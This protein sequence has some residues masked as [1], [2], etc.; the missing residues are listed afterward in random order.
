MWQM[1]DKMKLSYYHSFQ[2]SCTCPFAI[3]AGQ[4]LAFEAATEL[5]YRNTNL[6][7]MRWTYPVTN[8]FLLE[9]SASY[10]YNHSQVE[11]GPDTLP[12][13][14]NITELSTG[15]Q[16]GSTANTTFSGVALYSLTPNYSNAFFM[17]YGGT[18]VTGSHAFKVG[19]TRLSGVQASSGYVQNNGIAYTFNNQKPTGLTLYATPGWSESKVRQNVGV[20]GQDQWTL[21]RLTINA[22]V[23]WDHLDAYNPE[24]TRPGGLYVPPFAFGEQDCVPCWNDVTPRL[25]VAYD[26]FGNGKTAVKV[27]VGKYVNLES[28]TIASAANPANAFVGSTTRTWND[29]S[30]PAGDPRNG[31]FVPDCVMTNS[32]ANGECGPN[33]ASAFGTVR[34]VTTYDPNLINAYGKRPYNWQSNVSIQQELRP[35]VSLNVGYFRTSYGNFMATAN[36]A[37][38]VRLLALLRHDAVRLQDSR[39]RR[40]AAVRFLR[41]QRVRRGQGQQFDHVR[42]QLRR[43]VPLVRRH[44]RR[45]QRTVRTRRPARRRLQHRASG[46]RRVCDRQRAPGSERHAGVVQRQHHHR[47]ERQHAIL[48]RV[49]AVGRPDPGETEWCVSAALV[50]HEGVGDVPEL[51]GRY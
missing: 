29:N 30:F 8:K 1:T 3:S 36:Q 19:L 5:H 50:E 51:A 22:G 31:N 15:Y 10:L 25:G 20:Y 11:P 42:E 46:G 47:T 44:R 23:R 24:Q 26:V 41:P 40:A 33:A 9:A 2:Y 13:S 4:T 21:N 12:T 18:Y 16:Y 35:G 37:I 6:P 17:R 38:T 45:H 34:I 48:Q 14:P 28:T 27:S 43:A 49:A 7:Q 39:W 32:A